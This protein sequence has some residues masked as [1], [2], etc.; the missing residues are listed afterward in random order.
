MDFSSVVQV[1]HS[2]FY[3][4]W[5]ITDPHDNFGAQFTFENC[6]FYDGI[7]FSFTNSKVNFLSSSFSTES[8]LTGLVFVDCDVLMSDSTLRSNQNFTIR[9][10]NLAFYDSIIA[11][12][13]DTEGD[14]LFSVDSPQS[15]TSRGL[16]VSRRIVQFTDSLGE[17]VISGEIENSLLQIY[18]SSSV[19][20]SSAHLIDSSLFIQQSQVTVLNSAFDDSDIEA[21]TSDMT[22]TNAIFMETSNDAPLSL[23]N[24]TLSVFSSDVEGATLSEWVQCSGNSQVLGDISH[25]KL[26]ANCKLQ[27]QPWVLNTSDSD[28]VVTFSSSQE[29]IQLLLAESDAGMNITVRNH[30]FSNSLSSIPPQPQ[31]IML[32]LIPSDCSEELVVDSSYISAEMTQSSAGLS[33]VGPSPASFA[34]KTTGETSYC[35]IINSTSNLQSGSTLR[36]NVARIKRALAST[37]IDMSPKISIYSFLLR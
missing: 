10:G 2:N 13:N 8:N 12:L 33:F 1:Y 3:R 11:Y 5:G 20:I 7:Q 25:W 37:E 6:S 36:L 15:F 19:E 16:L 27:Y 26:A 24:S 23:V 28:A 22:L 9:G 17:V 34:P 18:Q 31:S 4:N 35:L 21:Y 30:D 14:L 29:M 32:Y